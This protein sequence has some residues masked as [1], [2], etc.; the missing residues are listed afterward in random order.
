[1]PHSEIAPVLTGQIENILSASRGQIGDWEHWTIEPVTNAFQDKNQVYKIQSSNPGA[2]ILKLEHA[3]AETNIQREAHVLQYLSA[4]GLP[5]PHLICSGV[6][7]QYRVG[8]RYPGY[9]LM[10]CVEGTPLNWV[11]YRA[12]VEERRLYL[13]QVVELVGRLSSIRVSHAPGKPC[14]GS[15]AGSIRQKDG[16]I[17]CAA[18][19]PFN[20]ES[21]GPFLTIDDMFQKQIGLW[22]DRLKAQREKYAAGLFEAWQGLDRSVLSGDVPVCLAHADIA[23][24][25]IIVDPVAKSI[26]GLIDWEFAGFY[27]VDMDFHSLLYFDRHQQWKWCGAEDV[28]LAGEL[29]G[30]LQIDRPEGYDDRLVWFDLLQLTRDLCRYQSWFAG[31]ADDLKRYETSL[32]KRLNA[33][34]NTCGIKPSV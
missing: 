8:D 12:A 29:M 19:E 26:K 21:I 17:E 28:A 2:L 31:R 1:M 10:D 20:Q 13:R 23:P 30:A 9:L 5:A 18:L 16:G 3:L 33:F 27:P 34:F 25:N 32:E 7:D 11:Y 14:I 15:V 22:L 24:M 6:C 4:A